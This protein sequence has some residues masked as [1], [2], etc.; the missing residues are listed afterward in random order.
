M[1]YDVATDPMRANPVLYIAV[2]CVLSVVPCM[3]HFFLNMR[4]P[5]F[6]PPTP[7]KLVSSVKD[8]NGEVGWTLNGYSGHRGAY[9]VQKG[10]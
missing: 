1:V 3:V 4:P 10:H 7:V 2:V 5:T 8:L 9:G 6:P